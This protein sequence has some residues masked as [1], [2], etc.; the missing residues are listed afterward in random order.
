MATDYIKYLEFGPCFIHSVHL[1][2]RV[3]VMLEKVILVAE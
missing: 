1:E 2:L 3:H